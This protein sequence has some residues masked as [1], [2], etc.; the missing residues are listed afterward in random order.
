MVGC[1]SMK[2]PIIVTAMLWRQNEN[3]RALIHR[4]A[5]ALTR[6]G[7]NT[8]QLAGAKCAEACKDE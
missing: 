4:G 7:V 8:G 6:A 3:K 1:G 5:A 2:L